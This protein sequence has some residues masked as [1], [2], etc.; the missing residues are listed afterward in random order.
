MSGEKYSIE[1]H[2]DKQRYEISVDGREAGYCAYVVSSE[3]VLDFNHTVVD[4]AFRGH[5]LSIPLIKAALDDARASGAR[6]RPSCSAVEQ[7]IDKNQDYRT[8]IA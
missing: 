4:Q 7:F 3:G 1:H 6:I 2:E 5:G 8:L